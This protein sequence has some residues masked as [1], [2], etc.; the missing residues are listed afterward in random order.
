VGDPKITVVK[1]CG[2]PVLKDEA[3]WDKKKWD[4]WTY[5]YSHNLYFIITFE[6]G[7]IIKIE[8]ERKKWGEP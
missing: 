6:A 5:D 7:K 4:I 2:E 8:S 1:L 3:Y